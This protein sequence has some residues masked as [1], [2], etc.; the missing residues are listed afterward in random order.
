M[1]RACPAEEKK[2]TQAEQC[3]EAGTMEELRFEQ[4]AVVAGEYDAVICGGGPSGFIA[5]T[6][7]ARMGAKV[8]LIE[9]YGFLGGMATAGYVAPISEFCYNGRKVIG[10]LPWEFI[11]DMEKAGGALVEKPLGNVSFSPEVYKICA[12]RMVRKENVTLYLHALF[13]GCRKEDGRITEVFMQCK[14]GLK[15]VR[16]RY[17][18]DC[19]GDGDLSAS[20]GI[21]MQDY[22]EPLQPA[23]LYFCLGGVDTDSLPKVHHR[24]QGINYHME[25]LR[26]K[27]TEIGKKEK[28]PVFGGPWMCWTTMPG[29][30]LV[31]MTRTEADFTDEREETRAE[32]ELH[33]D[34][35]TFVKTLRENF[36]PFRNAYLISTAVQTGVRETRHI[37][38]VHILT[39]EEYLSAYHFEDAVSRGAHPVDIHA[40][41][42]SG[43]RCEFLK[44]AAYIPYR[45][46]ITKECRNLLVPGR[47]FSAD[48]VAFASARVQASVMGLG[49]AAGCAAA[50]C[51]EKQAD[52]QD[53]DI[54]SL[55]S[56][57][58][59][60]GA[61]I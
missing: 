22:G 8:A 7:A 1:M 34:V 24:E 61:V 17:F 57:L 50:M 6:A 44:E 36:E 49:Q 19:T 42:G 18:L 46:L 10:G 60:W 39:G 26:E 25:D 27:L 30:V 11:E 53:V 45:S 58:T 13:C 31:N 38:G 55:R 29:T 54:V 43:Q 14:D 9:Q 4:K 37:R 35:F 3:G 48:R 15:A 33:E 20:A 51:A 5:A 23:S 2:N 59:G 16:G 12:Q 28:L 21:P 40:G 41:G 32:L 56:T 52:V 47:S